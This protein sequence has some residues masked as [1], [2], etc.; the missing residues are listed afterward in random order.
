VEEK[1][2][3]GNL[4]SIKSDGYESDNNQNRAFST[5]SLAKKRENAGGV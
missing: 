4:L 2:F 3:V 5:D 1:A